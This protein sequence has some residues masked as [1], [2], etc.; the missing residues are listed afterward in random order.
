[1]SKIIILVVAIFLS[2]AFYWFSFRPTK[3]KKD[4]YIYSKNIEKIMVEKGFGYGY[5]NSYKECLV[6]NGI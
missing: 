6:K 2:V 3:I 4:C 5:E 1:M